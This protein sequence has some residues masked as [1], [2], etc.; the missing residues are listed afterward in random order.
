MMVLKFIE[1]KNIKIILTTSKK[2]ATIIE[3]FNR[4]LKEKLY[5]YFEFNKNISKSN[6]HNKRY[7]NV[8]LNHIIIH[9]I[10]QL[11]LLQIMFQM[12]IKK[13]F[14]KIFMDII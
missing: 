5:R 9:I 6:L 2:K 8:L 3:R 1:S 7:I 10:V 14:L 12:K 13:K 11:K 4:T